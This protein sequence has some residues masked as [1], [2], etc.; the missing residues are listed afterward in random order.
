VP[1]GVDAAEAA[2]LILSWTTAY[3]LLHRTARVQRGQRVL[4]QGAAGAVGQA[5]LALGGMAGLELWGTARGKHAVLIREVKVSTWTCAGAESERYAC[6]AAKVL[7]GRRAIVVSYWL[8]DGRLSFQTL[9]ALNGRQLAEEIAKRRP[10]L[11]VLYTSGYAENAVVQARS[12]H[13]LA[14]QAL[15][16]GRSGPTDPRDHRPQLIV[17]G[18]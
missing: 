14:E 18:R 4:A 9:G 5:L 11:R 8:C 17:V 12:R 16:Q 10:S 6:L 7:N 3:H 2:A 15:L 13:C 1:A